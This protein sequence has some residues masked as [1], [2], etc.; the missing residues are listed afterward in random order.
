VQPAWQGSCICPE[1]VEMIEYVV[2]RER[3]TGTNVVISYYHSDAFKTQ[4]LYNSAQHLG[5]CLMNR[6]I[7]RNWAVQ[8]TH[9]PFN[10]RVAALKEEAEAIRSP[11][12]PIGSRAKR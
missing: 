3:G 7:G 9:E 4:S 11:S 10:L 2:E 6:G 8:S 1:V 12:T 5:A